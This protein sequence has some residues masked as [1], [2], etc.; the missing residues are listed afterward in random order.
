MNILIYFDVVNVAY[1]NPPGSRP[2]FCPFVMSRFRFDGSTACTPHSLNNNPVIGILSINLL[3]NP[4]IL[5]N[6]SCY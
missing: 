2:T 5:D 3:P 1:S 4:T 6:A